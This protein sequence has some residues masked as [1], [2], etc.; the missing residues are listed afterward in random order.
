MVTNEE[1]RPYLETVDFPTTRDE[2]VREAEWLGAPE[3]V[4]KAL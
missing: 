2:I 1:V 3:P 4:L